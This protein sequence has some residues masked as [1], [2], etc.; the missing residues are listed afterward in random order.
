MTTLNGKKPIIELLTD[1]K[2]D[3]SEMTLNF[4]RG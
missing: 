2:L 1:G 3:A 4:L